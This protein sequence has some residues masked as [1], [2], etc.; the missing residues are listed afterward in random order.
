MSGSSAGCSSAARRTRLEERSHV[1]ASSRLAGRVRSLSPLKPEEPDYKGV[2]KEVRP[3][4]LV[5]RCGRIV[6]GTV[7][8]MI[9]RRR[10][11]DA[12]DPDGSRPGDAGRVPRAV[13]TQ[14]AGHGRRAA[15]G[16]IERVGRPARER[17]GA[18]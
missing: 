2:R 9:A 10:D 1:D 7:E 16:I 6:G 4:S 3:G 8:T 12:Q 13:D 14:T 17:R 15:R 5:I 11:S 18:P